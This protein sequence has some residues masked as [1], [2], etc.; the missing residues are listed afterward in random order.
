ME[1]GI[2]CHLIE[3]LSNTFPEETKFIELFPIG[4]K[5]L[6]LDFRIFLLLFIFRPDEMRQINE[7]YFLQ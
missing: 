6:R 4:N 7:T 1:K 5:I 2:L 3:M